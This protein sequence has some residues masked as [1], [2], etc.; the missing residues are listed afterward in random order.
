FADSCVKASLSHKVISMSEKLRSII[1]AKDWSPV[2]WQQYPAG[3]QATYPDNEAVE[4]VLGQLAKLP[5]L[6][7]SWEIM[8]LK[9][10]IAAAQAGKQFVLQGGDCAELFSDC[11]SSIIT[12]R[13]KV[14]LQ[15]SLVMLQG[16]DMPVVRIGRFAGQY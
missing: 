3:Q 7:T 4:Q 13:L 5:P 6:V 8:A 16:M 11:E 1:P 12:N 10:R 15:A 2:S 14:L 9:K